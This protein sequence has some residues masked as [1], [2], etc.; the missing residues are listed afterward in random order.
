MAAK[1]PYTAVV[2]VYPTVP[3]QHLLLFDTI[4]MDSTDTLLD[5][6]ASAP[7]DDVR[8]QVADIRYLQSRGVLKLMQPSRELRED[9]KAEL[10][11]LEAAVAANTPANIGRISADPDDP[12]AQNE[13][14]EKTLALWRNKAFVEETNRQMRRTINASVRLL[15]I[16]LNLAG[17]PAVP[18][19]SSFE[20][21][22]TSKSLETHIAEVTLT[23]L[24]IPSPD[25]ALEAI[26][27]FRAD[28]AAMGTIDA[29]HRWI[30]RPAREEV[31]PQAFADELD[32]LLQMHHQHMRFHRMRYTNALAKTLVTLPLELVEN[33]LKFR[34]KALAE[35][36]FVIREHRIT[37]LEAEVTGPGR[38]VAYIS[39]AQRQFDESPGD[40]PTLP[41]PQPRPARPAPPVEE[42]G[43]HLR[44]LGYEAGVLASG[45]L[46]FK[47]EGRSYFILLDADD[48]DFLCL[49][50]RDFWSTNSREEMVQAFIVAD[51]VNREAKVAKIFF[52]EDRKKV[53][54]S[55]EAVLADH[56]TFNPVFP[57][58]FR[59]LRAA[60]ESFVDQMHELTKDER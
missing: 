9:Y 7:D 35:K 4:V 45:A 10:G 39:R 12:R 24:P 1:A 55:V 37:L 30:R 5:T 44:E 56:A 8:S 49:L 15:A 60:V 29:L 25:T 48:P 38:E 20:T 47:S 43:Q 6:Y 16:Q 2:P 57:R 42:Y 14:V 41:A 11:D 32:E 40:T 21:P 22:A 59:M 46:A 18:I 31:S 13:I 50:Y 26:L 28:E 23:A 3:K 52:D 27:E 36:P 54:A 19:V 53:S 51:A 34:L 33:I 58:Y 17:I